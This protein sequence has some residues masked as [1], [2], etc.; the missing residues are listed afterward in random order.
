MVRPP[1]RRALADAPIGARLTA[2]CRALARVRRSADG[3]VGL[4]LLRVMPAMMTGC[5]DFRHTEGEARRVAFVPMLLNCAA[6][7]LSTL[8]PGARGRETQT[9]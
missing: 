3:A 9:R 4:G 2:M 5:A 7:Q 8:S 1:L 6:A